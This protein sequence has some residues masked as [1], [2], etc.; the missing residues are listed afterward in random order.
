MQALGAEPSGHL[1]HARRPNG[2]RGPARFQAGPPGRH[3]VL[4]GS[5]DCEVA[6]SS[7]GVGLN[8][9]DASLAGASRGDAG[10]GPAAS[11]PT[12]PGLDRDG[13]RLNPVRSWRAAV[14]RRG[15]GGPGAWRPATPRTRATTTGIGPNRVGWDKTSAT[16]RS[17][18]RRRSRTWRPWCGKSRRRA[19]RGE[20]VARRADASGRQGADS[21]GVHA[22]TETVSGASSS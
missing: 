18:R 21:D 19:G 3:G 8:S 4:Q 14:S 5:R 22:C 20:M 12:G 11:E 6:V 7:C 17:R 10:E 15:A 9:A 16:G 2:A 13:N 1:A